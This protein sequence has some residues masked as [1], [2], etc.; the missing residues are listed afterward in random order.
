MIASWEPK[1][2]IPE[3]FNFFIALKRIILYDVAIGNGRV[4]HPSYNLLNSLY[5]EIR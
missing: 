1:T 5:P 2:T 4:C 3:I